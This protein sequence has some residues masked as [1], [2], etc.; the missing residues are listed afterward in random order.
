[1]EHCPT[2]ECLD[3]RN[4]DLNLT[5]KIKEFE[6]DLNTGLEFDQSAQVGE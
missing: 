3:F 1:M 6:W 5:I 4:P 2:V